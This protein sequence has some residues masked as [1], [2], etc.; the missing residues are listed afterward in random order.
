MRLYKF[1]GSGILWPVHHIN[2]LSGHRN[3]FLNANLDR[4]L[5]FTFQVLQ[6]EI[7]TEQN[8]LPSKSLIKFARMPQPEGWAV[9]LTVLNPKISESYTE[10]KV[11]TTGNKTKCYIESVEGQPFS[12]SITLNQNIPPAE[13]TSCFSAYC[14]VDGQK[15][16]SSL[17]GKFPTHLCSNAQFSGKRVANEKVAP[18]EFGATQFTGIKGK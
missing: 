12:I 7:S 9:G 14:Y 18:F 4:L 3:P 17:L 2:N 6:L 16:D 11:E 1:R 15:S 10:Y 8:R 13:V 5:S